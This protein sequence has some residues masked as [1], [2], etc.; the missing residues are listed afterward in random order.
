MNSSHYPIKE[1][2]TVGSSMSVEYLRK[3]VAI[4]IGDV[5]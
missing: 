2:K 3:D 4:G 1:F 5:F